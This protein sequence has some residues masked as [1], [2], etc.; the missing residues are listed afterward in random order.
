MKMEQTELVSVQGAKEVNLR[1][2]PSTQFQSLGLIQE[3]EVGIADEYMAQAYS[4]GHGWY[5]VT[6]KDKVGWMRSDYLSAMSRVTQVSGNSG[7]MAVSEPTPIEVPNI[8]KFPLPCLGTFTGGWS[9]SHKG[10]DIA[11]AV[12][13][14]ILGQVG[15]IVHQVEHCSKCMGPEG[16]SSY[17]N[18]VPLYEIYRD[19]GWNGGFGHYIV[20]R[21]PSVVLPASV[22]AQ[23]PNQDALVLYGHLDSIRGMVGDF[24]A[25]PGYILGLMGNTGNSSGP[26]LHIELRFSGRSDLKWMQLNNS[27]DPS[28]LFTR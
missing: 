4:T 2:G 17:G 9:A 20:V 25:Q 15:G 1:S 26:H 18:G 3:R 10:W 24:I 28:I 11:N 19:R 27:V 14:P 13:T 7:S 5:R 12:G 21:Y 8:G 16:P 22:R 6:F 23:F